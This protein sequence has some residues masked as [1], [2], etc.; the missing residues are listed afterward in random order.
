MAKALE[1][2]LGVYINVAALVSLLASV[3]TIYFFVGALNR[4]AY[5]TDT[6]LLTAGVAAATQQNEVWTVDY[7][8]WP[9]ILNLFHSGNTY[10]MRESFAQSFDDHTGFD[11]VVLAEESQHRIYGWE[12]DGGPKAR[13]NILSRDELATLRH[14]LERNHGTGQFTASHAVA[15]NGVPYIVSASVMGEYE[16]R[17]T[18][19]PLTD[20]IIIIGRQIDQAFLD[21]LEA[22]YLIEHVRFLPAESEPVDGAVPVVDGGGHQIGQLIWSPSLPGLTTLRLTLI[23]LVIYI[24]AFAAASQVIG[25]HVRRLARQAEES[26]TRARK[27]AGTDSMSQLPNRR[28]FMEFVES[29]WVMKEADK[30]NAAIIYVDL[31]GF[32]AIN[33]KAGH[34]A[35]DQ[36]IRIV[37]D[38]MRT[39]IADDIMI[40]RM[41][42]DEFACALA[43]RQQT[44]KTLNIAR[45]LSDKLNDPV[46]LN[47]QKYDIGAAIGVASAHP[48]AP[49]S[50]EELVRDA[51]LAMYRAKAEQ[52]D[53]P[54]L[55]DVSFGLE[56]TQRR[57]LE[58]DIE[59]GLNNDEFHVVYQPI[60]NATSGEIESVEALLRWEHES[61]GA[62][63]PD[64]FIP[65]AEQSK[66]I[67]RLGDLVLNSIGR[68]IGPDA[69]HSV[70]INLSPVQLNDTQLA[71]QLLKTLRKYGMNPSQVEIEL[72]ETVLIDNFDKAK[73]RLEE[74]NLAG[75]RINLDDFGTGFASMGYLQ[76]LPFSKIK[77]DKTYVN[78]I[79]KSD[80]QNKMLQALS[81][82]GNAL[83][84]CVVAEGVET[85]SQAKLL[86]LLG[87]D[88][89][90]GWHFGKPMSADTLKE[91]ITDPAV[92]PDEKTA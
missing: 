24:I 22:N 11:F 46:V 75:F 68:D 58:A 63:P 35:G 21:E 10:W 61:L 92:A 8:W 70:S 34:H 15:L 69:P 14:D 27:A 26:E 44:A 49:Q 86:R 17:T 62:V 18:T 71:N 89:L 85:E 91:R 84:L 79:G 20:P 77:I 51:D 13:T 45:A 52:L 66:L 57:E 28:G 87:F 5:R 53:H 48:G 40:A 43:G 90:Q 36:V 65:I 30:G 1:H 83:D 39:V 2:K 81:L 59:R 16:D 4:N 42:G 72:T 3:L 64:V 78:M 29:E 50:F 37:A 76:T 32:K 80:G 23:P 19:N 25:R 9:D 38:R 7:G 82:L 60:V 54:L 67:H 12:R 55:F 6:Q 33:D 41:G 74:L 31:N 56:S 88:Y 73:I 47:G